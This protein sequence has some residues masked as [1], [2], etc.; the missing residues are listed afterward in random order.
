MPPEARPP[1]GDTNTP[2]RKTY[3]VGINSL[4]A[5]PYNFK[6]VKWSMHYK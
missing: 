6:L 3:N 5:F 2:T 4:N 1:D